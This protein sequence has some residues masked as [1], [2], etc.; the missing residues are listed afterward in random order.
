MI[1]KASQ[2]Q[3]GK[4]TNIRNKRGDI[5][6]TDI[7]KIIEQKEM[8]WNVNNLKRNEHHTLEITYQNWHEKRNRKI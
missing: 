5:T 2:I 4:S 7:K 6:Y 3:Q 1:Q 8:V